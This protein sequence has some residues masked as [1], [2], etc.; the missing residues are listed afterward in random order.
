LASKREA[1]TVEGHVG[2][3]DFLLYKPPIEMQWKKAKSGGAMLN[4]ARP[5]PWSQSLT[6]QQVRDG[7]PGASSG[8]ENEKPADTAGA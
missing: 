3:G 4:I 2:F 1:P 6:R 8:R 7:G 5:R